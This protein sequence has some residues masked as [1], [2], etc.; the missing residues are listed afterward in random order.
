MKPSTPAMLLRVTPHV[1]RPG[2]SI[3]CGFAGTA[4]AAPGPFWAIAEYYD[5]SADFV[6]AC[7]LERMRHLTMAL[8]A[9]GGSW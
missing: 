5:G 9:Q 6:I 8:G 1:P 7:A 4:T 2:M 3:R